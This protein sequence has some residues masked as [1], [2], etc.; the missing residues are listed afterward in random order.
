MRIVK[1]L[2]ISWI[3][4]ST[5][6]GSRQAGADIRAKALILS[7]C[8]IL[9]LCWCAEW[10]LLVFVLLGCSNKLSGEWLVMSTSLISL[11]DD[12][13]VYVSPPTEFRED[14]YCCSLVQSTK[15]E[16]LKTSLVILS[17]CLDNPTVTFSTG[18][19]DVISG[20]LRASKHSDYILFVSSPN[21]TYLPMTFII[22]YKL[23]L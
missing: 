6:D 19:D 7:L 2:R 11:Q 10:L 9:V 17:R 1:G 8:C 4:S 15:V 13:S 20:Y 5:S 12:F 14:Y 3:T 21:F 22:I 18:P 23:L 16:K